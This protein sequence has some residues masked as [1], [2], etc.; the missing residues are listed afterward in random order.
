MGN[1]SRSRYGIVRA[2]WIDH[3]EV[4]DDEI[5]VLAILALHADAEGVCW[6]S[7]QTIANRLGRSR[8]WVIA[9]INRLVELGLVERTRRRHESGGLRSC[10]YRLPGLAEL[11]HADSREAGSAREVRS[12]ER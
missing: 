7:Q 8:P 1:S 12:P 5:A 11:R 3:P 9:V 10:L 6:P 4:G 2:D